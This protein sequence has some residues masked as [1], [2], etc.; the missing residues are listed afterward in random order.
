M[1]KT[2]SNNSSSNDVFFL[3]KFFKYIING[4]CVLSYIW[5]KFVKYFFKYLTWGFITIS[6]YFYMLFAW[7]FKLMKKNGTV[8]VETVRPEKRKKNTGINAVEEEEE[9]VIKDRSKEKMLAIRADKAEELRKT[10]EE[11]AIE[12][13]RKIL[14]K[15]TLKE[16]K[17]IKKQEEKQRLEERRRNDAEDY[18][19][20]DVQVEKHDLNWALNKFFNGVASAPKKVG[21]SFKKMYQN[22]T[23]YKNARNKADINRQALLLNLEGEDAEK[24]ATKIVYEYVARDANGNTV[25]GYF[26]AFSK[27]EVHSYLLSE[28]FE[29]YSIRTSKWIQLLHGN[30]GRTSN[31]RV[32]PKDLIFMLTQLSTYIKAGIPLVEALKILE[33]QYHK[34]TYKKLLSALVYDLSMGDSF[35][36]ALTKQGEAFPRLLI[37]MVKASELTGELPE[38]LDDMSDYYTE[39][40]ATRKQMIS[41]MTYPMIVLVVAIGV[42]TF[43]MLYVVP[44]FV[45]L[46]AAFD[47]AQIPEFTMKIVRF[48][49]FM[50]KN[51]VWLG[52]GVVAFLSIMIYLYKNIR[53]VRIALQWVAMHIPPLSNIII[54]NE[55]TLFTKT[56]ASLLKHTV[57]ITDS[58]EIL[59]KMT[60]NE[61]Y[62]SMM[63]DTITNLARGEKISKAFENMWA[64]PIPAYEMIVTGER[65]G[66][67]AEMMQ[68]VSEFYQELHRNAVTRLKAFIEPVLIVFLTFAV[69]VIVLAVVIPMFNMYQQI[70]LSAY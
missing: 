39:T 55:V 18:V 63:L 62:K 51:I 31:I 66:Q 36:D 22:S 17:F 1:G 24:S 35:S 9:R 45:E 30:S 65:T 11:R 19:N 23:L 64:F 26:D 67:L 68:K 69:G 56:F 46:Y 50:K 49:D 6:Y 12:K 21:A 47:N 4:F 61:I 40:E 27:V 2:N 44:K 7:P 38:A 8:K 10:K 59:N 14:E 48:S 58:M 13:Q 52:L 57:F 34:K 5:F 43:I 60:N 41:A 25:K 3:L 33:T 53:V 54:Y 20:A 29:V 37:N 32:K 42:M 16:Q 70:Q 15:Q 28:G